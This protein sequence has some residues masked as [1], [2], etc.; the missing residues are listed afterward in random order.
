MN[1]GFSALING[2]WLINK[3][4]SMCGIFFLKQKKRFTKKQVQKF[5]FAVKKQS[6]RGPDAN[7][8]K[9]FD[10]YSNLCA[11]EFIGNTEKLIEMA[12]N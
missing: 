3:Y 11:T 6:Y 2:F 9:I 4:C 10:D 8:S 12:L 1:W 5:K 7:N